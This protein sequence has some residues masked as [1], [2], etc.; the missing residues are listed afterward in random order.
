MTGN[1]HSDGFAA[2]RAKAGLDSADLPALDQEVGDFAILDDVDAQRRC[3]SRIAP[4]DRIMSRRPAPRLVEATEDGEARRS[5]Q[6]WNV[7]AHR[8]A[9]VK[10]GV[11][12]VE[13][14]RIG[15]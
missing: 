10:L 5:V 7:C 2:Y 13:T 12:P 4:G 11:D 9:V 8:V 15:R 3:G 6:T 1:G 14:H